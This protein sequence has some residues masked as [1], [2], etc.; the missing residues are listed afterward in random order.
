MR[1]KGARNLKHEKRSR[2]TRALTESACSGDPR[3]ESKSEA[4]ALGLSE[5]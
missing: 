4:V 1:L 5:R 3:R 2:A